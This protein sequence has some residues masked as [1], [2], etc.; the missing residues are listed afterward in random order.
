MEVIKLEQWKDIEGYEGYY[1]ISNTGRIKSLLTNRE[2]AL[3]DVNTMGYKRVILYKPVRK[4]FFVH[5]LVAYH[6]C[7][8]YKDTLVV[9]HKDGNKQ[10]NNAENLEWVTRSEN[11]LHAFK[12]GLR[13]V[14]GCAKTQIAKSQLR[15]IVSWSRDRQILY[16]FGNSEYCANFF[17]VSKQIILLYIRE[18]KIFRDKYYICYEKKDVA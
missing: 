13:H 2:L 3:S 6:F 17:N 7:D 14:N 8:G 10:N 1:L 15:V 16:A 4:R 11:D 12:N 5:R 18:N 9:N